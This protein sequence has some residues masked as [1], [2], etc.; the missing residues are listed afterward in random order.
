MP[1]VCGLGDD[2]AGCEREFAL[3]PEGFRPNYLAAA[4]V[5]PSTKL[6]STYLGQVTVANLLSSS[7]AE[8]KL[9]CKVT[10]GDR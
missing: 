3:V 1:H 5:A 2:G 8:F 10:L 6:C 7:P 4:T 9:E